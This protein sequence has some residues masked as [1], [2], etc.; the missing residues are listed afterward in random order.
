MGDPKRHTLADMREVAAKQ[1]GKC[2]S[3][4]Y[5]NTHSKLTWQCSEGHVWD[6]QPNYISGGYWCPQCTKATFRLERLQ[7]MQQLAITNGGKCLSEEYVNEKTQLKW[8]CENGHIWVTLP[9]SISHGHWCRKCR[10]RKERMLQL[11]KMQKLARSRGGKCLSDSFVSIHHK[12]KWQCEH[13]HVWMTTPMVV[14]HN[15]SWCPV[16]ARLRRVGSGNKR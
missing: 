7:V 6:T 5:K 13:G 11:E 16:C 9:A 1:G 3:E 14:R 10:V 15:G 12:L 2:L 8:Q 4:T